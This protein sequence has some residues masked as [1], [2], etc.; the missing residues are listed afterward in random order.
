MRSAVAIPPRTLTPEEQARRRDAV[1]TLNLAYNHLTDTE[2]HELLD[3]WGADRGGL[4][5]QN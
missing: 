4:A 1:R 3:G 5:V 2:K